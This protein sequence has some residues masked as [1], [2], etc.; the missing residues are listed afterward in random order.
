MTKTLSGLFGARRR[1]AGRQEELLAAAVRAA[2]DYLAGLDGRPEARR[3]RLAAAIGTLTTARPASSAETFDALLAAGNR[4][5]EAGEPG[6][7]AAELGLALT[8]ADTAV[9]LRGRSKGAWRL[10]GLV[11]EALGRHGDAIEAYDRHLDLRQSYTESQDIVLRRDILD[12]TRSCLDEAAR[13]FPGAPTA[14][15]TPEG[16]TPAELRTAFADQVKARLAHLDAHGATRAPDPA[17][18]RLIQLYATYRRLTAEGRVPDPL[19]GDAAPLGAGPF[20]NMI[21][22]KAVCLVASADALGALGPGAGAGLGAEIDA[23]D[24]VIR[25]DSYRVDA[26]TTGERTDVHA[27]TL[28]GPTPWEGPRWTREVP[29]RL[30]FGDPADAWRRSLRKRLAP[31]AQRHIGDASLRRPLHDPALV[32]DGDWPRGGSTAF[33]V[34]RLLDF[35]DV[36]PRIDL[37]GLVGTGQL[38]PEENEWVTAHARKNASTETRTALR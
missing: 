25:C 37:I 33:T 2:A 14:L 30:V 26:P 24:V 22:G 36:N 20:R 28:R 17:T 16:H 21:A 1:S 8:L 19:V 9:E 3:V 10:R 7:G 5:F 32:G 31:G 15:A 38:R 6:G 12:E 13:L 27:V 29:T 23:Y 4:A 35:L 18:R 11:L 34:L